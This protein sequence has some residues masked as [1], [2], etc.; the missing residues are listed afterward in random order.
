[1]RFLLVGEARHR[2]ALQSTGTG[3]DHGRVGVAEDRG[4][5]GQRVID[6]RLPVD[7]VEPGALRPGHPEGTPIQ[8][9]KPPDQARYAAR[10]GGAGDV[11]VHAPCSQLYYIQH[12]I[13]WFLTAV[14]SKA[15]SLSTD[16]TQRL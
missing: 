6:I 3:F 2:P 1:R 9:G 10:Q 14:R 8:I 12:Q 15:I 7:V 4:T 5:H 16:R 11:L 13:D